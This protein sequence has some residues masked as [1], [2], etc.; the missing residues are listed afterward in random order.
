[1]GVDREVAPV[2]I[3]AQQRAR[4]LGQSRGSAIELAARRR[5]VDFSALSA[6]SAVIRQD[7]RGQKRLVDAHRG[8]EIARQGAS[9]AGAVPFDHQ[10]EVAGGEVRAIEEQVA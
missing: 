9:E 6:L 8:A 7:P 10:I 2:E 3:L 1:E 4:D 5:D